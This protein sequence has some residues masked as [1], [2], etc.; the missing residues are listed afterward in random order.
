MINAVDPEDCTAEREHYEAIERAN[1][2][3]LAAHPECPRYCYDCQCWLDNAAQ[4][5]THPGHSLH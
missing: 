4:A 5:V 2:A 3:V 1:D